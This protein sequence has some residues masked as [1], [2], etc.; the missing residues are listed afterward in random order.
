[1]S[2]PLL[3]EKTQFVL[4]GKSKGPFGI[5]PIWTSPGAFRLTLNVKCIEWSRLCRIKL[6]ALKKLTRTR[7]RDLKKLNIW[8]AEQFL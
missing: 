2:K 8:V 5:V 3:R 7:L 1:M 6:K 4:W